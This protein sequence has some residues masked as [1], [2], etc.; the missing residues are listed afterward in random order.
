MLLSRE[1]LP[2][3]SLDLSTPNGEFPT[4]PGRFYESHIRILDL[5]GRLRQAPSVLIARS[6]TTRSVYALERHQAGLYVVCKLGAWVSIEKLSN[7]AE[8]CYASRCYPA[9]TIEAMQREAATTTPHLYQESKRKRLAIEE[10]QSMVQKRPR[11][12]PVASSVPQMAQAQPPV[13]PQDTDQTPSSATSLEPAAAHAD[14]ALPVPPASQSGPLDLMADTQMTAEDIFQSIRSSC[15]EY[16]YHNKGSLAYFAKGPL[17]RA[18]AAFHFDCDATLDVNDL[19]NFLKSLVVAI[20]Q[21]DKKYKE[22]VP[23][24]IDEMKVMVETSEEDVPQV[25]RRK[26]KKM[27]LGKDGLW[28]N[29]VE[30]VKKWWRAN[31]PQV[32][33]DDSRINPQEVKYHIAC[34]RTRE[35]QLQM[36]ILLEVLALEATRPAPDADDSQLPGMPA[37]V[38][39]QEK[40]VEPV[41][42]KKT[43][44]DFPLLVNLHADRMSIWQS[45]TLDEMHMIA[46]EAQAKSGLQSQKSTRANSDP[47]KDFCIDI[48]VPL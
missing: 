20:P 7:V 14:S 43:K 25:K 16:L 48:V 34:L 8:A 12:T 5:D 31:K 33:E 42:K 11:T 1:C 6:D 46:A 18:R 36:I 15:F 23:K 28:S 38:P 44:H 47:L 9:Q 37:E 29:E 17:S 13:Q 10:L 2:L 27:K 24:L 39:V 30:Q 3:S 45:T 22:T 21:I 32:R 19:S 41:P 26:S 40:T 35:T 4:G